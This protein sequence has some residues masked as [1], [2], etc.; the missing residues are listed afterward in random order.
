MKKRS[1]SKRYALEVCDLSFK[2]EGQS[3]WLLKDLSFEVSEG[4]CVL[5]LGA[6]GTGKST[7]LRVLSGLHLVP[8]STI[9]LFGED[10]FSATSSQPKAVLVADDFRL[11][12]DLK[13]SE[14][15]DDT[16]STPS[17][18]ELFKILELQSDW[19]MH[20]VSDG[21]RQRV[22]L[23]MALSRPWRALFLDEVTVHLDVNTR[24]RLLAWIKSETKR[25]K[26]VSMLAT[27]IFDSLLTKKG[28]WAD[29]IIFLGH[30]Q[31]WQTASW[32]QIKKQLA[33]T[34]PLSSVVSRWITRNKI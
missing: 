6:N 22:Q 17:A 27:H 1:P 13:V 30:N 28:C 20:K 2:Y 4:K 3:E 10:P 14:L 34:N 8:S 25:R 11:N 29:Q 32:Q 23:W 5:L 24:E 16:R 15:M 26:A 9:Q 21:Q 7:L 19:R 33:V 18:R 31:V 12:L